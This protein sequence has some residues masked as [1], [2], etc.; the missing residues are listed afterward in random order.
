MTGAVIVGAM[1]L[2]LAAISAWLA[3]KDK[4]GSGWALL[5]FVL[6]VTSYL[7]ASQ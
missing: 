6:I 1:G 5:A 4:D 2:G 7:L 3:I